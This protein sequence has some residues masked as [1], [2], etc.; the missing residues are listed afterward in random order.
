LASTAQRYL[1]GLEVPL[2]HL[3]KHRQATIGLVIAGVAVICIGAVAVA[4]SQEDAPPPNS[5]DDFGEVAVTIR[6]GPGE[7][8]SGPARPTCM[9]EATTS[10]QH[11]RG[12]MTVTDPDLDGHDGM[13]FVYPEDSTGGYWMR[14]TPMPL[15]IVFL[16]AGGRIVS[17][18]DMSPCGDRPDCPVYPAAGPYRYAV[19]VPKGRLDD[20]GLTGDARI[21]V[22]GEC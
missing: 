20:L 1:L 13:I 16:D 15:S 12:L 3:V 11:Q 4:L 17:T 2:G 10:A 6:P 8:A 9:L 19:E 14:N 21:R 18:T 5:L 22:G 7:P